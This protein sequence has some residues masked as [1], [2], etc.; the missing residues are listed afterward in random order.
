L[1][2]DRPYLNLKFEFKFE[3]TVSNNQILHPRILFQISQIGL[4][5]TDE[6]VFHKRSSETIESTYVCSG[7]FW[8]Q[9]Y[10]LVDVWG[11]D[12]ILFFGGDVQAVDVKFVV[13]AHYGKMKSTVITHISP[14]KILLP[15]LLSSEY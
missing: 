3:Q 9:G 6:D 5:D 8:C 12:G 14:F 10:S 1:A 13:V 7:R 2:F 4:E 15:L 11:I